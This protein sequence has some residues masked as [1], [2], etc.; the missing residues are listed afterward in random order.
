MTGYSQATI[1][2]HT[3]NPHT[4]GELEHQGGAHIV[5]VDDSAANLR[6]YAKI[7]AGLESNVRVHSFNDPR[8]ALEWLTENHADLVITDYKMPTMHGAEFTRHVRQVPTCPDVPV[9]VVT[10]YADHDFR[11]EALE[12]GASDF[13]L[14]PVDYLEFQTRARNLVRLG[15]HQRLMRA[16]AFSL[17]HEL[18]ESEK[19]RDELLRHSR[20]RLAQV[21][22]T[23]PAM[24][25]ATDA[26]GNCIFVNAYQ[27]SVLGGAL[28]RPADS[29]PELDRQVLAS[30]KALEGF[31][32]TFIDNA[33][34]ARTFLTV[35]SPLREADGQT[36]GVL[37][38]SLDITERKRAEA[39]LVYLAQHDH[40]TTL[41]NRAHLYDR[42][43]RELES[44]RISGRV[45][46]LHFLDLDRF[47]YINDGLGHPFGNRLLQ[48][49]AQ[50]LQHAIGEGDMVARLG[51]DEFA[52]IQVTATSPSDA[53]QFASR[54]NQLLLDPFVI[55]GRKVVT[56]AS[57]GVTLYPR[58][59]ESVEELLQNADLAMYR[60][61]ASRRGGFTFFAREMLQQAHE[62]IRLQSSLPHAL[63]AG[64]FVLHYQPQIDLRSGKVMGAEAL[65]R[66]QSQHDGLVLPAGFLRAAEE[67]GLIQ[68]IDQW[69]LHEACRQAKVWFKTLVS[70]VRVSVNLSPLRSSTSSIFD[71]VMRQ[72]DATGLP[73]TLLGIELTEEVLLQRTHSAVRDLEDL[74]QR[75]VQISVDDFGT[76]YSSLAR[77]TSLHVDQL[78]IERTF[79]AGLEDPNNV[80]IIRAVV[81]LGRAL[82]IEVL[83]EG[84]ETGYQVDQVRLAG[85]DAVQGYYTGYPM[86]A[87]QFEA[88]LRARPADQRAQ[89][90]PHRM[91]AAQRQ[92]ALAI[93]QR[94]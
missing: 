28:R 90:Q 50:R 85:C 5:I 29:S 61:K 82:N 78:K 36:I 18:K 77:L 58:D 51:G 7:A 73:P 68:E 75:G 94:W 76:G 3:N 21:I 86:D 40:L 71:M 15:R 6:I 89:Q 13:L 47:K 60:V 91:P 43:R 19:S 17:E 31:E 62:A 72:L 57:I 59:G 27:G 8:K 9:V 20:E 84:A 56:S 39:Q 12:S 10:A 44:H 55:D 11:I 87:G 26:E 93:G 74:Q 25:S 45:F 46:A 33:G 48:A 69:V 80:A 92:P 37:T 38:S 64:E 34:G 81:G 88:F 4:F 65:I 54:I 2:A 70:P 42:L 49:V 41:P 23:V 66:W 52:I 30:G 16:H 14:S 83:A 32:E 22:D 24:I 53:A 67:T 79:V 63:E 1:H 35:K